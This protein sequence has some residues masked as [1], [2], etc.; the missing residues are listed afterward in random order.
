[1][2]ADSY[3]RVGT[4]CVPVVKSKFVTI[5]QFRAGAH[6]R[7]ERGDFC[8]WRIV[9]KHRAQSGSYKGARGLIG[10][11]APFYPPG[12]RFERLAREVPYLWDAVLERGANVQY[13]RPANRK[14]VQRWFDTHKKDDRFAYRIIINGGVVE[15]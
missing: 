6:G 8:F 5:V 10:R 13:I 1:M 2:N 11:A 15:L 7:Q 4:F 14:E 12:E 9:F 3:T